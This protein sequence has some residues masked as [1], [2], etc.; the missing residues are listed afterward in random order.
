MSFKIIYLD[1]EP[2][3]CEMFE[4][5]FSTP[6]VSVQT[7]VDPEC[8]I[9][10]INES[11]PDLVFLDYRLP[12]TTGDIVASRLS[13][14]IPKALITGDLTVKSTQLFLRVFHKPFDF[15]EMEGFIQGFCD[16]KKLK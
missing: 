10:A 16:R 3:L 4:D 1:D 6:D 12:K 11:N 5:N 14:D 8:A 13:P 2:H 15:L 7:F 9:K